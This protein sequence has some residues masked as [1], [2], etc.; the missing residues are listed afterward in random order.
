VEDS[1]IAPI[2]NLE[3]RRVN[4]TLHGRSIPRSED[5]PGHNVFKGYTEW[6]EN[7]QRGVGDAIDLFAPPGT[8]V[9]AVCDCVQIKHAND[10]SRLEVIYLSDGNITAVYAHVN[11]VYSGTGVSIS[12]GSVVGY[13]RS[14]LADPHVHFEYWEGNHAVSGKT[15]N[16]LHDILVRRFAPKLIINEK[17]SKA[18]W[19]GEKFVIDVAV[20]AAELGKTTR[21]SGTMSIRNAFDALKIAVT[22]NTSHLSSQ[23][24]VYAFVK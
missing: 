18:V 3:T 21:I 12:Q 1:M 16:I 13:I 2:Q 6:A 22:F 10:A 4:A 9:F 19:D 14:D 8:P 7:G 11:A 5:V 23:G 20:L 17:I 24:K 15:P